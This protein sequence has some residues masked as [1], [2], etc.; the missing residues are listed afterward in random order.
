MQKG[1]YKKKKS[2]DST[3]LE[4]NPTANV[5]DEEWS[6]FKNNVPQN[7]KSVKRDFSLKENA[8]TFYSHMGKTIDG[9]KQAKIGA[10]SVVSYLTGRGVKAEEI[11]WSGIETFLEGK[12]SVT[13]AELQEFVAGRC[14]A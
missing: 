2:A 10:D 12:K 4:T 3:L 9:M 6:N 5:Q 8:P 13:K 7:T 11:K 1:D 14:F